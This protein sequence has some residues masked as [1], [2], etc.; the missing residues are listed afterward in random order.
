MHRI[1]FLRAVV[2]HLICGGYGPFHTG[3]LNEN[4]LFARLN[5][6]LSEHPKIPAGPPSLLDPESQVSHT[7]SPRQLPAWLSRLG[8]LDQR[9]SDLQ[10]I[11]DT[12][13]GF[14]NSPNGEVFAER[15]W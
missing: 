14:K 13:V 10:N 2:H 15:A 3:P 9:S 11:S 5:H 12:D 7:P 4:E 8:N 1:P 6:P